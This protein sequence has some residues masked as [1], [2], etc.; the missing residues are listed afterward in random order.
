MKTSTIAKLQLSHKL[1]SLALIVLAMISVV[2]AS[3]P[4][5]AQSSN[6]EDM[7]IMLPAILASGLNSSSQTSLCDGFLINDKQNRPMQAKSRPAP[8]A[9]YTDAAFGSKIT[10]VS[11]STSLSSGIIRTLYSTIQAWNADESLMLL[12]HRGQGHF[13]YH[14]QSY[15]VIERIEISPADIEQ[16]F[17]SSNDPE[18]LFYP[19][20]KIGSTVQTAQG[21]YLLK[22]KELM[23]YNVRTKNFQLIKDLNA[24]CPNNG[25]TAGNDV[26]MISYDDDLF[27]FRC[28]SKGFSYRR[29]SDTVTTLPSSANSVAPQPFPSG[30]NLFHQGNIL[31][32]Q[33]QTL[34]SLDLGNT[35]EHS[36]LG[37]LHNGHDAY[38][39]IAFAANQNNSCG[40]GIGSV[41]VH[42]TTDASC[43]VL[44]GPSNGYPYSLSG[45]HISALAHKRPGW[46]AVSSVGYG[47]EGDSLL[48]QELYIV[49]TDP[50]TPEVCRIAHH[51]STGRR[52]SIGYFAE[53]HPVLS[54]S[55]TRV[56]FNSDW[57]NSGSVDVFVV[58]LPSFQN[59]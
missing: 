33:L 31:N 37:R 7:L 17:W 53:P 57:N 23:S 4:S 51:R 18:L 29:S 2:L 13:L 40:N 43:R 26:Q 54:P 5:I 58:E 39:A 38:F 20:Q 52:G 19:N 11:D 8:G 14:G 48:E 59:K 25:V 55:G 28:G 56:L 36:S 3:N 6:D 50:D 24:N 42:D 32:K 9:T 44:V 46:A 35:A 12:W 1:L 10:R 30:E 34:R 16:V 15:Q 47:V 22:G 21:S 49:N 45:T 41:V 27:G